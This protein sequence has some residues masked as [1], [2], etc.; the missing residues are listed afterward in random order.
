MKQEDKSRK[1][2]KNSN[3]IKS[4]GFD[5]SLEKI[6]EKEE[7]EKLFE[8][9]YLKGTCFSSLKE[10]QEDKTLVDVNA[11]RALIAI[12]LIGIWRG[13]NDNQ[14]KQQILQKFEE[15][16]E[17]I[18]EERQRMIEMIDERIEELENPTIICPKCKFSGKEK[19]YNYDSDAC[20]MTCPKC[21]NEVYLPD[22]K[23]E[24]K[25]I[26]DLK[27]KGERR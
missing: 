10:L 1:E 23:K 22:Y 21:G 12:E 24:I 17:Q 14:L 19:D 7:L 18:L 3:K 13:L 16:E 15:L 20:E 11:P 26:Q 25:E 2:D 5:T 6:F 4:V 8:E 27:R 9:R